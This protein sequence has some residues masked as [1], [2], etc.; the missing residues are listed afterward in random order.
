MGVTT[1]R[2]GARLTAFVA[3]M[4]LLSTLAIQLGADA[5]PQGR[6]F[7]DD[8][9]LSQEPYIEAIAAAGITAGCNPPS[10]DRYCPDREL[11]RAEMATML[12]RALRLPSTRF[13]YFIDDDGSLHEPAINELAAAAITKGCNPPSADRYCPDSPLTRGQMAAFLARSF[14]PVFSGYGLFCH[15]SEKTT[16]RSLC[17]IRSWMPMTVK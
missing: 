5:A 17:C 1:S 12:D 13:D 6:Q 16:Q 10:N 11:T 15:I 9:G 8:D 2:H 14:D 7:V 3:V 4:L